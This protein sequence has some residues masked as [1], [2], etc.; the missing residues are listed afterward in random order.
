M[1]HL[2]TIWAGYVPAWKQPWTPSE[3]IISVANTNWYKEKPKLTGSLSNMNS[4]GFSHKQ[5]KPWCA[6]LHSWSHLLIFCF[7]FPGLPVRNPSVSPPTS[8]VIFLFW[9]VDFYDPR[10]C[11]EYFHSFLDSLIPLNNLFIPLSSINT[12]MTSTSEIQAKC[13]VR[14]LSSVASCILKL[15]TSPVSLPYS[16]FVPFLD[17]SIPS[18]WDSRFMPLPFLI[19]LS[20]L[21]PPNCS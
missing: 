9:S 12:S 3:S 8:L 10:F 21:P 5:T 4:R 17:N 11:P 1:R 15:S 19:L 2:G 7:L 6:L 18:P 16:I 14:F 20:H 13:S